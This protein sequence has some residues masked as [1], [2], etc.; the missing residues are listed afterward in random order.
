M[1]INIE[2]LAP[3][4]L[5]IGLGA[6]NVYHGHFWGTAANGLLEVEN[7]RSSRDD[8]MLVLEFVGALGHC[9]RI[10]SV[11][12]HRNKSVPIPGCRLPGRC[13]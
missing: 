4:N 6:A 5:G 8:V 12:M 9:G 11:N 2:C 13:A 1:G 7:T 3:G 10:P